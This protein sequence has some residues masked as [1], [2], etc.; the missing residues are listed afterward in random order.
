MQSK[1]RRRTAAQG[2][3]RL[4]AEAART[5]SVTGTLLPYPESLA[6]LLPV[7]ADRGMSATLAA[8]RELISG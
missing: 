6:P 7:L 4:G 8:I 3:C 1:G 2:P 5:R